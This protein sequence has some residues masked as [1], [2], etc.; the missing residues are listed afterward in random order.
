MNFNRLL[1]KFALYQTLEA[2]VK[3]IALENEAQNTRNHVEWTLLKTAQA[4]AVEKLET[5]KKATKLDAE[6][7]SAYIAVRERQVELERTVWSALE[8]KTSKLKLQHFD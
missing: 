2:Q 6:W 1:E 7:F 3:T 8:S 5:L 4:T